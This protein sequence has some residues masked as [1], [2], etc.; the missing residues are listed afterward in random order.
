MKKKALGFVAALSLVGGLWVMRLGDI[1]SDMMLFWAFLVLLMAAASVLFSFLAT[2]EFKRRTY[3]QK[4]IDCI[5]TLHSRECD[6]EKKETYAYA[7]KM[8]RVGMASCGVI[9]ILLQETTWRH[10]VVIAVLWMFAVA[11]VGYLS[12]IAWRF[13][14]E[15]L[16]HRKAANGQP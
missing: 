7:V 12:P 3:S 1:I 16:R 8:G 6:K 5:N 4:Q 2:E 10:Q 9:F 13:G 11:L 14:R 15:Y